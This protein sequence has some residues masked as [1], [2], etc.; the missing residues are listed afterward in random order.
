MDIY[1]DLEEGDTIE[2]LPDKKVIKVKGKGVRRVITEEIYTSVI[3]RFCQMSEIEK[4]AKKKSEGSFEMIFA[5]K[6]GNPKKGLIKIVLL[7]EHQ[8]KSKGDKIIL[9]VKGKESITKMSEIKK[10]VKIE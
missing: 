1:H 9:K 5:K 2:V 6:I 4:D 7:A 8:Q 10:H 3:D